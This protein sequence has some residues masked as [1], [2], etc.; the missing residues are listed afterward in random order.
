M[1][2]K[3]ICHE[4]SPIHVRCII[5]SQTQY[6]DRR[7]DTPGWGVFYTSDVFIMDATCLQPGFMAHEYS[8]QQGRGRVAV[9]Q[10]FGGGVRGV[11]NK[12]DWSNLE[13]FYAQQINRLFWKLFGG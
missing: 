1:V 11:S 2:Y 12:T 4:Q 6:R 10:I 13:G 5:A 3:V 7:I 8:C 9:L